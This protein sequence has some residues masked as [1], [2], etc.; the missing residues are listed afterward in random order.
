MSEET[1]NIAVVAPQTKARVPWLPLGLVLLIIPV[2]TLLLTEFLVVPRLKASFTTASE[3]ETDD[4]ASEPAS[5]HEESND[6][7]H[8]SK[9]GK[10][11]GAG[12]KVKFDGVVSNL[13]GTMGTRF[14]KV[15]FELSGG[16]SRLGEL[17]V[18]HRTHVQD[19]IITTLSSHTIQEI[20]AVGGRDGLRLALIGAINEAV[21]EKAAEE[22]YFTEFIIQ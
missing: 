20:E 15:S 16:N 11:E 21:G 2:I 7:G 1:S 14:I 8:G 5:S 4:H 3:V 13:S 6:S 10:S 9:A 17:V 12:H 18:A 22:L 19:A